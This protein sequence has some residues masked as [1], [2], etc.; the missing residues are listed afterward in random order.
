MTASPVDRPRS[1]IAAFWCWVVA[2]VLTAALGLFVISLSAVLYARVGGAIL[3]VVGLALGFVVGRARNGQVR[4][5][6][7]GVGLAMSSVL[8]LALLILTRGVGVI[9]AAVVMILLITGAVSI[10]RPA[11]QDWFAAIGDKSDG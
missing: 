6:Y 3:L 4:F 8:Y 9:P 2:A 7:A 10:T 11:A 5:A 1:V